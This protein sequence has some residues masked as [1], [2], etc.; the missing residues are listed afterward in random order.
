MGKSDKSVPVTF[1]LEPVDLTDIDGHDV[2]LQT[3]FWGTFKSFSGHTPYAYK[4]VFE[5]D[6]M[7]DLPL[8]VLVR[9]I[10]RGSSLAYVPHGPILPAGGT[11]AEALPIPFFPANGPLFLTHLT[12][13]L[14]KVLPGNCV[15]VRY[16]LPWAIQEPG[17]IVLSK[18]FEKAPMDI[19][20]PSTV[21]LDI[22][23][24][25]ETLL[26]G[27]K[28]KTRYNIRL[29]FRKGVEVREASVEELESWY[30][31]YKETA[32]RD[33]IAIHDF[34]Y[35]KK[36]FT[37]SSAYT[38][39]PVIKLLLAEIEGSTVAGIIVGFQGTW[40]T[41]LFG[42]SSTQQRNFMP[43]YALQWRAIELA[44][45]HGCHWYDFFGIPPAPS[46][47]HPM[48]G[49]YRFKVG[50]GGTVVHRPGCW[51]IP[52]QPLKYSLYRY[53]EKVRHYYYKRW[54]KR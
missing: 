25:E 37:L 42:A 28:S 54:R 17:E 22:R 33:R 15:F 10:V 16:D 53:A 45:E 9:P 43:T 12:R 29:A 23:A 34:D 31:L 39:S 11:S 2:L 13:E 27:M 18:P 24:D 40:A 44:K 3:G 51:D 48:H 26:A 19:Q 14:R 47:D 30:D 1:S 8:L 46:P 49:L 52:L 7:D 32:Q 41:Y 5:T 35:Y 21:V 36:L 6:E 4:I 50:F 20:P 38:N